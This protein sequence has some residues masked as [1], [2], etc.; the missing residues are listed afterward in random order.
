ML[1]RPPT[2]HHERMHEGVMRVDRSSRACGEKGAL[3]YIVVASLWNARMLALCTLTHTPC[4]RML[5]S[6]VS[7]SV[8]LR[9]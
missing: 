7:D 2:R 4:D 8:R 9:L 1:A 3:Q 5:M 6:H